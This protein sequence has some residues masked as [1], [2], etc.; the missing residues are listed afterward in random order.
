MEPS[1]PQAISLWWKNVL[2]GREDK[3]SSEGLEWSIVHD[4]GEQLF[5]TNDG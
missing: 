3:K 2:P 4:E 1:D 5:V